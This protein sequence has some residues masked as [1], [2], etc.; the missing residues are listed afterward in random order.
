MER[1]IIIG[2]VSA[3]L[4]ALA[5]A[6]F[7]PGGKPPDRSPQ[8][9][10]RIEVEAS[11][12]SRVFG[13]TLAQ[14]TLGE[15][16]QQFQKEST[17]SLFASPEGDYAIEAYFQRLYLSG[18]RADL[19]LNIDVPQESAVEMFGRGI[20]MSRLGSG[21]SKVTLSPED[22]IRV[23]GRPISLITYLPASNLEPELIQQR[24]GKPEQRLQEVSGIEHW[25]YPSKGLDIAINP[26]GKEVFQY[27]LPSRFELIMQ[28]LLQAASGAER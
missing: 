18:I 15:A 7:L 6:L 17:V 28:P 10:W 26:E 13:L 8:L 12:A 2:L 20:R 25:L 27:T 21:S 19:V 24:F 4:L 1:H 14:S 3:T 16:E 23:K 9:P 11:G 5:I 22:L